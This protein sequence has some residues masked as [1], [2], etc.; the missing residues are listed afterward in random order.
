M[1]DE[2][3]P[4]RIDLSSVLATFCCYLYNF[5][6]GTED[7]WKTVLPG[8]FLKIISLKYTHRSFQRET[9][10]N[11]V[12]KFSEPSILIKMGA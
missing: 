11:F 4:P 5:R 10:K 3:K 8:N 12:N 1:N 7:F 9:R 6:N 2:R